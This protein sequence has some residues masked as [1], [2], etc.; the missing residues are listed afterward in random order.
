[1]SFAEPNRRKGIREFSFVLICYWLLLL[2]IAVNLLL[3]RLQAA[4]PPGLPFGVFSSGGAFYAQDFSYNLLFL[5]G[6][7]E[8]LVAHPYCLE[9]QEKLMRRLLP[10]M[11]SGMSH[12]YSPVAFVLAQPLLA[13]S[14]RSAYLI[15]TL[16]CGVATFL[17]YYF[18]LLPRTSTPLQL[19]ALAVCG[20]SVWIMTAFTVGQSSPLTT[21]LVGAFWALLAG[22]S[23]SPSVLRDACLAALFWALC[24]KPSIALLPFMLLLGARAWRPFLFGATLV[25]LT[26]ISV[27]GYYGGWSGPADYFHLLNHY[28]NVDFIP[29]MQR[30]SETTAGSHL[31]V[32]WFSLD[33]ALILILGVTLLILRWTRLIS[34]SGQFRGMIGIF[35]LFSPYLL[36]SENLILCLLVVEGSFFQ[37][38]NPLLNCVKLLLLAAIFD[39]HA[40]LTFPIQIDYP[41]KCLLL[42]WMSAE[43]LRKRLP[44]FQSRPEWGQSDQPGQLAA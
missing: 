16:L 30:A 41:V 17:L 28:N 25:L 32:L 7:Q 15:F 44:V 35:L 8:R 27:G 39:L 3:A 42:A 22:R 31:T 2:V 9:D 34:P 20:V 23:A 43:P 29:F 13:V 14:G 10:E 21:A 24:L 4:S 11:T 33:R 19:F 5:H 40:G 38:K 36:P 6:V 37:S 12:A 18:Y 1:M 26:W